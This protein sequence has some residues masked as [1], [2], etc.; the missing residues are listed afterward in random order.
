MARLSI[1]WDGAADGATNMAADEVLAAEAIER[2]MP[3][4]RLSGWLSPTV[5]L[6]AFQG[7]ADARALAADVAAR[8]ALVRRPSGGGAIV[9]GT[10]ITYAIAIPG[11]HPWS[12]EAAPLYRAVHGPLV[13]VLESFGLPA[14]V[15]DKAGNDGPADSASFFCFSRRSPGDVVVDLSATVR[16]GPQRPA[17]DHAHQNAGANAKILGGAQRRLAGAVLQHG[18]LLLRVNR[19]VPEMWRHEGLEELGLPV[20]DTAQ[21]LVEAWMNRLATTLGLEA[22]W[23]RGSF[24]ESPLRRSAIDDAVA[25]YSAPRWLERR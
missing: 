23:E 18:S 20:A 24:A 12:R 9:H 21:G 5:S 1:W 13:T 15:H 17:S 22:T 6:G 11:G 19:D 16:G 2:G 8:P 3:V 25:R 14:R 10:D 4:V 7:I